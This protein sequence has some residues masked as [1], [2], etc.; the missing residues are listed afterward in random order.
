[1]LPDKKFLLT[2]VVLESPKDFLP[3]EGTV[4]VDVG[5][6]ALIDQLLFSLLL[7]FSQP[8]LFNHLTFAAFFGEVLYFLIIIL[9]LARKDICRLHCTSTFRTQEAL[10][11]EALLETKGDA[12]VAEPVDFRDG[13]ETKATLMHRHSTLLAEDNLVVIFIVSDAANCTTCVFLSNLG[14]LMHTQLLD[15][16]LNLISL[17]LIHSFLCHH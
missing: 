4:A 8:T 15:V 11:H 17:G 1:M 7:E 10:D 5:A 3:R 12:V 13:F 2:A 14:A 6:E 16:F 9:L